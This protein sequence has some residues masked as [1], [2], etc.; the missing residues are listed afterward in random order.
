MY[1]TLMN[2]IWDSVRLF[3]NHI[4]ALASITL[5]FIIFLE[6]FEVYFIEST[7]MTPFM[8][9]DLS[10][11]LLA[12]LTIKPFYS[13]A[14]I[15]YIAAVINNQPISITQSWLMGIKFWPVY[16][17]V[18][19]IMNIL[20]GTGLLF[21][22]IPGIFLFIRFSFTEFYLLLDKQSPLAAIKSSFT[23]TRQYFLQLSGGF[24]ILAVIIFYSHAMINTVFDIQPPEMNFELLTEILKTE[25][26]VKVQTLSQENLLIKFPPFSLL[27]S[28]VGI[29]FNF[30][31]IIFTIF[32][33]RVYCISKQQS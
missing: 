1:K 6:I 12:H 26:P 22:A 32:A 20:I 5:P 15:F 18:S 3:Q 25:S 10:P 21:Y 24:I 33:F 8:F 11:L 4:V 31:I 17:V 16:F 29:I 7:L 27:R 14:V 9:D 2:S 28:I 30:I 13:I 23:N 19:L